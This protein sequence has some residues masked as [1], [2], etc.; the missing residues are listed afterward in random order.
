MQIAKENDL[1]TFLLPALWHTFR[2]ISGSRVLFDR[3]QNASL[4]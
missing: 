1:T 3:G 4:L 2:R